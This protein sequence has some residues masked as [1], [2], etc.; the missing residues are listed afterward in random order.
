MVTVESVDRYIHERKSERAKRGVITKG[1]KPVR[2]IFTDGTES[3]FRTLT[4]ARNF[5]GLSY[6]TI[7][8]A[9]EQNTPVEI[10]VSR[11]KCEKIGIDADD[12][13]LSPITE[14]VKFKYDY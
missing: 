9:L 8:R 11:K 14:H 10:A 7:S 4:D 13:E 1:G 2:A 3:K 12:V 5:F 6:Y